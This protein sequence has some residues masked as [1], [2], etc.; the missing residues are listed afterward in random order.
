M[1]SFNQS[2]NV[3]IRRFSIELA[4]G[5]AIFSEANRCGDARE[6]KGRGKQ[7]H[8]PVSFH[9]TMCLSLSN[10]QIIAAA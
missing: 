2:R 8:R 4:I 9:G 1:Q 5:K 10:E 3:R 6:V 7:T